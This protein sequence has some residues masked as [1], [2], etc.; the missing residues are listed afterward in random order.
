MNINIH[1]RPLAI[2]LAATSLTSLA[3]VHE[4]AAKKRGEELFQPALEYAD[5]QADASSTNRQPLY[6]G[7]G[8]M[9]MPLSP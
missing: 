9:T 5:E 3:M 8:S 2:V 6:E 1:C 7:L 4:N